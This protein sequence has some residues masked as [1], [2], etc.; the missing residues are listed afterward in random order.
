MIMIA[1]SIVVIGS[2]VVVIESIVVVIG[3]IAIVIRSIVV[4]ATPIVV[5]VS[6]HVATLVARKIAVSI[7][8]VRSRGWTS[9]RTVRTGAVRCWR[10]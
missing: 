4:I 7:G 10:I 6:L 1:I 9:G 3:S 8:A 5:K 2:I